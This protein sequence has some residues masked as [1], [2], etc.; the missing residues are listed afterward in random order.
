MLCSFV[1]YIYAFAH[2]SKNHRRLMSL[3]L[4]S[5]SMKTKRMLSPP[6]PKQPMTESSLS[7]ASLTSLESPSALSVLSSNDNTALYKNEN[8]SIS[9]DKAQ[10]S[11]YWEEGLSRIRYDSDTS[12]DS[13]SRCHSHA[14]R[15]RSFK[16][17]MRKVDEFSPYAV[18]AKT[19]SRSRSKK[20][21]KKTQVR[22]R[23]R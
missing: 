14:L 1:M 10:S 21:K 6:S 19:L 15:K 3:S 11:T 20:R 18:R 8:R 12:S 23:S 7:E 4:S 5:D 22:A 16:K 2:C 17:S 13:Y 9:E